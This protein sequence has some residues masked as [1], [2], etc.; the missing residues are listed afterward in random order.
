LHLEDKPLID[1]GTI[2]ARDLFTIR[3]GELAHENIQGGV[4]PAETDIIK[5][6][7]RGG[8]WTCRF[9]VEKD[10]RCGIYDHRP[11]ECRALNCQDTRQIEK[12]YDTNRLTRKDLLENVPGLWDVI[13]EHQHHCDYGRIYKLRE[14]LKRNPADKTAAQNLRELIAYDSLIRERLSKKGNMDPDLMD[15]LF[16]R[17]L[18]ARAE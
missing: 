11:L 15:F 13:Q 12:I 1:T 10:N 7:G 9:L 18:T 16:G 5:I 2:A 3:A 8:Q 14:Q 17:P 6:K 4:R